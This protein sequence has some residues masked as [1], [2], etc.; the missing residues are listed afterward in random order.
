M[1]PHQTLQAVLDGKFFL[2]FADQELVIKHTHTLNAADRILQ[3]G[4]R[5]RMVY[6][7]RL[8]QK[9]AFDRSEIIFYPVVGSL[10]R[11]NLFFTSFIY[12]S[13]LS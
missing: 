13:S 1:H 9:Q 3:C 11:A 10:E 2:F 7:L 12:S 6:G 5:L 4:L 8:Q